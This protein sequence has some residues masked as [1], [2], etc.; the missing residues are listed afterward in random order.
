MIFPAPF[1]FAPL[2]GHSW[3]IAILF[4]VFAGLV[5]P[6]TAPAQ[7]TNPAI[8]SAEFAI[9]VRITDN[10][11]PQ[12]NATAVI[13]TKRGYIWVG[14]Y[15]GI[16]QFD[17][18]HFKVFDSSNS[19]GLANSRVTSLY[20]DSPGDVWIGHDTGE[21]T[22]HT[23]RGFAIVPVPS[24]WR[25]SPIKDFAEDERGDVWVLNQQGEALRL[26]DH[27]L[28][29]PTGLM[30]ENPFINP[31]VTMDA[32]R[33]AY[34]VR[35]GVVMQLTADRYVPVNF[36]DPSERPYYAGVAAARDGS[37]WVAGQS[38]L[39]KWSGTNWLADVADFFWADISVTTML[40]TS[41]GR[42]VVGT[43]QHGLY[44]FDPTSG[45]FFV[46][47][48]NGLP[49]DWICSIVEDREKNLWVGTSGGLAVLRERKV[50]M[51][52]PPDSWQGRPIYSITRAHDGS[53]WAATEGAGVYRLAGTNW[54][55][56]GTENGLDNLFVWSVFEDSQRQI[57]AGT[58]GGGLF[59]FESD[60]FVAQTN[61]IAPADPVVA[62]KEFPA[63][64]MWIGTGAGLVRMRSN[65]LER[66]A[67]LGGA[68]AGDVRVIEAGT[69][70]DLWIGTQGAGLGRWRND[71]FQTFQ[72][73]DGLPG[74]FILSLLCESNGTLWIGMLDQ[75]L[76]RF[77]NGEFRAISNAH[78]L[79]ANTIYHLE[80]DQMGNFW[81]NSPVGLFRVS[82]R[83][84]NAVADGQSQSLD[85]LAYGTA[86]G[87]STLAGTGGFTPSGF[88]TA[89]GQL[90]FSTTRG[91]AVVSPKTARSNPV[92]PPVWIEEVMVDGQSVSIS[93]NPSPRPARAKETSPRNYVVLQPGRHLMDVQFTGLSFTSPERVRFKYRLENLDTD[94]TEAGT[95][96]RVTYPFLPPGD[97][98]FHV[99]ACNSDGLWNDTGDALAIRMLPHFWQ[100]LW[101]KTFLAVGSCALVGGVVSVVSRRRH[102]QKLERIARER[103]LERERARIAQDIHDDLGASLTRIGLLSES[104]AGDL[105]NPQRAATN[106]EQII[107][108]TRELTRSMDEIVWA[109]NPR[110]DTLESLSNYISRFAHDF[111]STANIRCRL[112]LPLQLPDISVR[113]EVRHN[114][115]LA[116]KEALNNV[117][118]HSHAN[119]V[120]L[121]LEI[122]PGGLR[123]VIADNGPGFDLDQA[124]ASS[125]RHRHAPGNG[126][127]NLERRLQ[128]IGGHS[129]LH[130]APGAGTSVEFFVPVTEMPMM[131]E[132]SP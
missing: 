118:K 38:Q 44:I 7:L 19:K 112:A 103:A 71:K 9:E 91:I 61:L 41:S 37:L 108:T 54:Q 4:L 16:A 124:N 80:D 32:H 48:Q 76:C 70:G 90:W 55:H 106:L 43:L 85:A 67:P 46:N 40:E 22:H 132:N 129:R 20:A 116:C 28:V 99:I 17:G 81:L 126:L 57:W 83:E 33:R 74:N 130:S 64:T 45:W 12:N 111:L 125:H 51:H 11:L 79:P 102:R 52:S 95:R 47:R 68:A 100:T 113:S 30:A 84:L 121:T 119:E 72:T 10:G 69:D 15:N 13:Q 6:G 115:F 5:M 65:V 75:G 122:V 53:V 59:R 131:E 73:K 94:W 60:R 35:N 127:F 49:Q 29:S 128:Q 1:P 34:V 101:F 120:R 42:V 104:T 50:V 88:R 87:M 58:W 92:R 105:E 8:A 78:G 86:E 82:K 27:R 24:E 109:V 21:V 98:T 3:R 62:L 77:K 96:R 23:D 66:F 25:H 2:S 18:L 14:T 93:E 114:L 39:R 97:Y 110:H 117:V 107:S 63:G 89:D 26:K 123:F 31:R 36:G 56:Y